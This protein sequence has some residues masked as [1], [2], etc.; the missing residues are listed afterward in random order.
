M[1]LIAHE[2]VGWVILCGYALVLLF[3]GKER[4]DESSVL[5][6]V[7]VNPFAIFGGLNREDNQLVTM[8]ALERAWERIGTENSVPRNARKKSESW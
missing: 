7:Y 4:V 2:E 6:P 8:I 5:R 3:G 1:N